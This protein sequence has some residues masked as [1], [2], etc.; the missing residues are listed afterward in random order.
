[1]REG[2]GKRGVK[3]QQVCGKAELFP[4][5]RRRDSM[6]FVVYERL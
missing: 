3:Q 6:G 1:M 4:Y 2:R 5:E